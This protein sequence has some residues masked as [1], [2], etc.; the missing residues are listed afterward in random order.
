MC[1]DVKSIL[2]IDGCEFFRSSINRPNLFYEVPP[3]PGDRGRAMLRI[4]PISA[5]AAPCP[6]PP[7][8]GRSLPPSRAQVKQKP[9]AG[10]ELAKDIAQFISGNYPG[11]ESGIVYVLA[12]KDAEA[13]AEVGGWPG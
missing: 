4:C 11:G 8:A 10:A 2:R 1:D 13:L 9:A 12:R 6:A 3:Q 7:Q 5:A